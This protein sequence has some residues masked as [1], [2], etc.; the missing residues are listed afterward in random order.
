[1]KKLL[2]SIIICIIAFTLIGCNK[3]TNNKNSVSK[4]IKEQKDKG[5]NKYKK[6]Q[7]DNKNYFSKNPSKNIEKLSS[8]SENDNLDV[9]DL[10]KLDSTILFAQIADININPNDYK[11]KRIIFSGIYNHTFDNIH[12]KNYYG[13]VTKDVQGC[14]VQGLEFFPSPSEESKFLKM[15]NMSEVTIRGTVKILKENDFARAI[16]IECKILN[17]NS[18]NKE[19]I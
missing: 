7:D 3:N 14:C 1:M 17:T 19:M 16:L 4:I 11:D 9:L 8:K 2:I 10:R 6:N 12:N 18:N 15:E 13:I 5:S